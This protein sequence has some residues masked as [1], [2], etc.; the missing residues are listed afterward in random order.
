MPDVYPERIF[1]EVAANAVSQYMG[2]DALRFGSP[3]VGSVVPVGFAEAIDYVCGVT[4]EGVGVRRDAMTGDEKDAGVDVIAWK[5]I[6]ARV[7]KLMILGSCATGEDWE[8]KVRDLS[9]SRF[10][11]TYFREHPEP[12]PQKAFFTC[13]LVPRRKWMEHTRDG[14]IIF[15]R[16]RVSRLTPKMP[17]PTE[18]GDSEVWMR[19]VLRVGPELEA[20]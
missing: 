8:D 2:G 14:G 1:E 12:K 13:R 11:R 20:S 3:R 19:E 4:G 5:A 10:C 7:G 18:H 16:L 17:T 6:D 15:D 9:A